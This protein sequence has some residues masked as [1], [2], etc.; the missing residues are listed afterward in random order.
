MSHATLFKPELSWPE[1]VFRTAYRNMF[2]TNAHVKPFALLTKPRQ[3]LTTWWNIIKHAK[4]KL[5][6]CWHVDI[7]QSDK[8]IYLQIV[9]QCPPPC[10]QGWRIKSIKHH[11]TRIPGSIIWQYIYIYSKLHKTDFPTFS[12]ASILSASGARTALSFPFLL[13]RHD[14][15]EIVA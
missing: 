10:K 11:E 4:G 6:R 15:R 14:S 8:K 12:C 1:M 2:L 5:E 3:S 9:S 13:G 7:M